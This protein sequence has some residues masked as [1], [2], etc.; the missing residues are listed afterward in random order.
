MLCRKSA[1]EL[2]SPADRLTDGS[3]RGCHGERQRRHHER[4]KRALK[5]LNIMEDAGV[6]IDKLTADSGYTLV[7]NW[8]C[9]DDSVRIER[10]HPALIAKWRGK[11]DA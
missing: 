11:L 4:K 9:G 1:H 8:L 2:R 3:C 6:D 7:L 5:L 10:E